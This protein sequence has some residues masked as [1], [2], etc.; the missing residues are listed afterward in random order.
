M[1][2]PSESRRLVELL[3]TGRIGRRR[4]ISSMILLGASTSTIGALLA[5]CN[6]TTTTSTKKRQL[7]V[8]TEASPPSLDIMLDGGRENGSIY[9]A[10]YD[11]FSRWRQ[12]PGPQPG[13]FSIAWSPDPANNTLRM[14]TSVDVSA[15]RTQ[16]T[17]HLRKGWMSHAGNEFTSADVKYTWDRVNGEPGIGTFLDKVESIQSVTV[18]DKYTVQFRLSEPGDSFPVGLSDFGLRC[19]LDSTEMKKR[20]TA[21]DPW[22]HKWIQTHDAGFGPWKLSSLVP[23]TSFE[24]VADKSNPFP[25]KLDKITFR[26]IPE[27]ANRLALVSRGDVDVAETLDAKQ[28]KSLEGTPGVKVWNFKSNS[29]V[30]LPIQQKFAPLDNVK[31]RQALA[32]AVPYDDIVAN[33]YLGYAQPAY[34]PLSSTVPNLVDTS[35]FPYKLDLA[36]A[37]ALLQDAGFGN[38]FSTSYAYP[39]DESIAE[40]VGIQLQT[41]FAKIG[42]KLALNAMPRSTHEQTL[43]GGKAPLTYS[44]LGAD[45]P[46]PFYALSLFYGTGGAANFPGFSSKSVDAL[47]AKAKTITDPTQHFDFLRKDVNSQIITESPWLWIAQPG[48]QVA[49]RSNVVGINWYIGTSLWDPLDFM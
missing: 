7:I 41:S 40:Q 26:V 32:Y 31:V 49:T 1:D 44:N 34:G 47:I 45:L 9:E 39:N 43:Y 5:A 6:S 37:K 8:A 42:V 33:L 28:L 21:D 36:K 46:N 15:D 11:G 48:Y 17:Y 14:A 4:F 27:S 22:S 24:L 23:D 13:S 2:D 16:Y 38:G 3:Q 25:P 20:A 19:P 18:I 30:A 12:I 29:L 10:V 35:L